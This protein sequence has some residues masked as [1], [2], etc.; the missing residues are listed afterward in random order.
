M[1]T[2]SIRKKCAEIV[3]WT[4]NDLKYAHVGGGA[5]FEKFWL[6]AGIDI[7]TLS[8]DDISSGPSH[9]RSLPDYPESAD[10]ALQ[11]VAWMS[12]PENGGFEYRA[13]NDNW[14]PN[15]HRFQFVND[16][17]S[18]DSFANTLPLAICLAF[19]RANGIEPETL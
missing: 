19:L 13:S 15:R 12:K 4:Y 10:A 6:P 5:V 11:L 16:E 18:F 1:N 3:G 2:E 7:Q 9:G 14:H 17:K 8:A